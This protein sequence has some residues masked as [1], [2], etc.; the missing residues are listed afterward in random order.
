MRFRP[1]I[2]TLLI[3]L[4]LATCARAAAP[5]DPA[6]DYRLA[7]Q[8]LQTLLDSPLGRTLP[9]L[10]WKIEILQSWDVNAYSS[11]NGVISLTRGLGWVLGDHV[12][13]WA[14]AIAHELAH[15]VMLSPERQ[16]PFEAEARREYAAAGGNPDDP[17]SAED[18][19]VMPAHGGMLHL[20]GQRQVEYEADRLGLLLM[21]SAG[22]HPDFAIALDR[23]ML[24]TIGE[25][26]RFSEFL[27]SHP[28]WSNREEQ[29][30]RGESVPLAI[31][32][33]RW[34]DAGRSPGGPPPPFGKVQSV[35]VTGDPKAGML[36]LD[37]KFEMR[38]VA[39]RQ[40]RLAAIL[41][42]H[43]RKVRTSRAEYRAPDGSLAVNTM[44]PGFDH[45][46]GEAALRIPM[47]AVKSG[48]AK[49][50]AAIFLVAG[51]WTLDLWFQPLAS[52]VAVPMK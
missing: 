20:G 34:P 23:R 11:G 1:A 43:N 27:A 21:A 36:L 5:E 45:G 46:P 25:D 7:D 10:T 40:A 8:A 14:A 29:N 26:A 44:L 39:G 38:N 22:F 52:A 28:I 24:S 37:V 17:K 2:T 48:D 3:C 49:L 6:S 35:T 30:A 42:D 13:L 9:H 51:E 32:K 4:L 31:F 15:S 19:R 16:P 41:L 33:Q 50:R 47:D 18:L 12:G